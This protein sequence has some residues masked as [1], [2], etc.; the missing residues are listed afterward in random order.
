MLGSVTAI[1]PA[2][3]EFVLTYDDGPDFPA[4][5]SILDE[6][7]AHGCTA[8]FFVLMTRVERFG[9]LL[10]RA[11]AEGHEIGL[12]GRDHRRLTTLPIREVISTL[13]DAQSR[14]QDRTGRPVRWFR[15]PY[16]AQT[17]LV[18]AA[19]RRLKMTTV[20]WGPS[21][22]DWDPDFH[23]DRAEAVLASARAGQI[24][25]CHDGFADANDLAVAGTRPEFDRGALTSAL[26][27]GLAESGLTARSL[28]DALTT[29]ARPVRTLVFRR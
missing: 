27:T 7:A 5:S 21:L 26:L 9:Q 4:T 14:L 2:G 29:G 3:T 28:G 12:H 18:W 16:G 24:L 10:E 1:R 22:F 11:V 6:L 17:P 25:L 8:T 13:T 15:P 20:L 23:P 19:V